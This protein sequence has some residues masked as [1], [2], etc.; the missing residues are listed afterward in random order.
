MISFYPFE[1][2]TRLIT[3][4]QGHFHENLKKFI[5]PLKGEEQEE[6]QKY[7]LFNGIWDSDSF[8]ISL[9]LKISNNF[10]PIIHGTF[11]TSDEGTLIRLTYAL[12]PATKKL[13]MFWT[14]LTLLITA[15]F[16]GIHQAW[17]YGAISFGFCLVNYILS[18]ENFRI[19]VR[20]SRRMLDKM[21]S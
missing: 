10:I 2:E 19:Q 14:I 1:E 6:N 5:K 3:I 17:L 13:L 9:K 4:S 20:K 21:L 11:L 18:R 16:I 7:F 8:S 15:F 12:F